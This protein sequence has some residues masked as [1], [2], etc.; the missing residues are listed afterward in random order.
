[1]IRR[2]M[3]FPL[4][5]LQRLLQDARSPPPP[6]VPAR[7]MWYKVKT[8]YDKYTLQ[9]RRNQLGQYELRD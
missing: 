9:D 7:E 8:L 1:M 5:D 4:S 3:E 2:T 6:I